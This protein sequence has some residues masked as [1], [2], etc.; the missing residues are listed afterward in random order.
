MRVQHPDKTQH[1]IAP[2]L[3]D[4]IETDENGIADVEDEKVAKSLVEQGWT[5]I[6]GGKS[7]A[8]KEK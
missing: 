8:D 2:A 7:A 5:E 6:K 4:P 3:A 1:T